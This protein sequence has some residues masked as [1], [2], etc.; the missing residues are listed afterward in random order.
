VA[1][2]AE[3]CHWFYSRLTRGEMEKSSEGNGIELKEEESL[4]QTEIGIE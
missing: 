1:Q 2:I 4:E 3:D